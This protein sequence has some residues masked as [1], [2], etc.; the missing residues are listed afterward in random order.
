MS[1][2][3]DVKGKTFLHLLE[4]MVLD[5]GLASNLSMFLQ[6]R[7]SLEVCVI[8]YLIKRMKGFLMLK[9]EFVN[10]VKIGWS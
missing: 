9:S 1:I 7:R 3:L 10:G 6:R 2:L 4:L 5:L 8:F